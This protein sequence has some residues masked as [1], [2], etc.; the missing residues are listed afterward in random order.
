MVVASIV[1]RSRLE[2]GDR[3]GNGGNGRR[4]GDGPRLVCSTELRQSCEAF[5]SAGDSGIQV[6]VEPAAA[7]AARLISEPPSRDFD[8]WLVPAPWPEMVREARRTAGHEELLRP[9][10][11][12]ARSPL[13]LAVWPDRA[14][15]LRDHCRSANQW[16]CLGDV[17]GVPWSSLRGGQPIW[18]QV[19]PGHAH[20][21]QEAM[22]LAVL[23]AAT[24]GFFGRSDLSRQDILE[25]D[26][27]R[28]WLTRLE[29]AVPTFDPSAQTSLEDMVVKGPAAFD[30][31][32][33]SEAEAGPLL[34]RTARGDKPIV[35]YPPPVA[36]A[37]VA[38][39]TLPGEEADRLAREVR[40]RAGRSALAQAGWR[41]QGE[42]PAPG[43]TGNVPLPPE[44]GL[45]APGVL[46][47][48]RQ[49][50]AEIGV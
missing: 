31:V 8:G 6:T 23:A 28:A 12:L 34:A 38:L 47:A 29:K 17:A 7:T 18:G 15:V 27:F 10:Q 40:G 25:N 4:G 39:A 19:R 2:G 50:L 33:T 20:P 9:G 13:V 24:A 32:G 22:G 16:R 45:P 26:A 11:V 37:D 44:S 41:V 3:N 30:A 14:E 42:R 48:L 36:T 43:L 46:E 35:I 5:A 21:V 1:V 49:L